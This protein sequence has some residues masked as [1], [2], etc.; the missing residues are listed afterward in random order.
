MARTHW[1]LR[2]RDSGDGRYCFNVATDGVQRGGTCGRLSGPGVTGKLGWMSRS[3][4]RSF[5]AGAVVSRAKG[6][7]VRLS[8]GSWRYLLAMAPTRLIAPG[9][10]F[11][12]TTIPRGTHPVEIRGH[13]RMGRAVV[14]WKRAR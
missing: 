4:G 8:S 13:T 6:V 11:F 10:S 9:I 1:Q 2:V 5:V 7:S 12:F 3:G 14:I